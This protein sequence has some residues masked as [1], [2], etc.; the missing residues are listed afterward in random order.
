MRYYRE[1]FNS[2]SAKQCG[3]EIDW[4]RKALSLEGGMK[5]TLAGEYICQ[6]ARF[7]PSK[8]IP[9]LIKAFLEFRNKL[10]ET[11]SAPIDGAPQLIIMGHGSIDD[12]DGTVV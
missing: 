3:V 9:D 10:D 5:L 7:D 1:L 6:I 4:D 8:G 11:D 2:L 12:P